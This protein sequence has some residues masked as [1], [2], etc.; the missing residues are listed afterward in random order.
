MNMSAPYTWTGEICA[1]AAERLLERPVEENP[2]TSRPPRLSDTV[3]CWKPFHK[4]GY[5]QPAR[6]R[7]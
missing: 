1:E 5:L 4:L 6:I 2:A 7:R 3:N